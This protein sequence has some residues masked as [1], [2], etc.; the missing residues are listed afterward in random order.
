M[1]KVD[2]GIYILLGVCIIGIIASK[3]LGTDTLVLAPI[4]WALLG[5]VLGRNVDNISV[6][7]RNIL[8]SFKK[9]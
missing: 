5:V 7:T 8:G 2:I 3:Y 4:T 9:K 6:G 1:Q